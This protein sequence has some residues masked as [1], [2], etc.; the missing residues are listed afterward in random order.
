MYC[1]F[2]YSIWKGFAL[3]FTSP[4][5]I[6]FLNTQYFVVSL[7]ACYSYSCVSAKILP[8]AIDEVLFWFY[9]LICEHSSHFP[10]NSCK[11]FCWPEYSCV[12]R[13][14]SHPPARIFGW[15]WHWLL[16]PIDAD[17]GPSTLALSGLSIVWCRVCSPGYCLRVR[18]HTKITTTQFTSGF[19]AFKG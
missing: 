4:G 8:L 10:D 12:T 17:V 7:S 1:L 16:F 15:V 14:Q 3:S 18:C 2:I 19:Y 6:F 5:T 13:Q 9:N 11:V